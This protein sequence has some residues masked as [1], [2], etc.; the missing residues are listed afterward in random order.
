MI[1]WLKI[2]NI[3]L[4]L[5]YIYTD[6]KEYRCITNNHSDQAE[7]N[8]LKVGGKPAVVLSQRNRFSFRIRS[9]NGLKNL[10]I[11]YT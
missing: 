6:R 7:K 10:C 2:N 3:L 1:F 4:L 9:V 5:S 11:Q 8:R